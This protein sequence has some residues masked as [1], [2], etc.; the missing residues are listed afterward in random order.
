M[1]LF[2]H[3]RWVE[4][5]WRHLADDE[6]LGDVASVTVSLNRLLGPEGPAVLAHPGRLGV[7]LA[8]EDRVESLEPFLCRLGLIVVVFANFA[9]G[10]GF[11]TARI[12]RRRLAWRGELR[13]AGRIFVDQY[14]FLRRCGFDSFE[15]PDERVASWHPDNVAI[16]LAYRTDSEGGVASI[17]RLRHN[18][19][20][21][22]RP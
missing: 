9:D 4:D 13:A 21:E 15:V 14:S 2:A 17:W 6:P 8:T 18:R 22:P 16:P 3:G 12:L 1:P 5:P 7:R 10:R 20:R 11:S 19:C